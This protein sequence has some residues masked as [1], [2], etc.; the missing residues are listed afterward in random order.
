ML[1]LTV[2]RL[3][4]P[5]REVY[6]DCRPASCA[7]RRRGRPHSQYVSLDRLGRSIMRPL[8]G[9]PAPVSQPHGRS[10]CT[11]A[12]PTAIA[13][14]YRVLYA[15]SQRLGAFVETL[16]HFRP[17]P[18]VVAGR[19]EI[20]GEDDGAL[21]P[22]QVPTSW[23]EERLVAEGT[24]EGVF[25]DVGQGRSLS[26]L[27]TALASRIVHYD[28]ADLDGATIRISAPRRFTQEISRHVFECTDPGNQQIS[29]DKNSRFPPAAAASTK[30]PF[31]GH[32]LHHGWLAHPGRRASHA[33]RVPRCRVSPRA[34]FPPHLAVTQLPPA[35]TSDH[36][37]VQRTST[38]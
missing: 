4:H 23:A 20:E 11:I 6:V 17:D 34:S 18:G 14:R 2:E 37:L 1:C 9:R 3:D 5:G 7:C 26:H 33:V 21:L 35:R 22:G 19:A 36:L 10:G 32:G 31:G 13:R 15:C 16:A 30:R 27:R 28:M 24:I 29:P 38:S 12:R 25:A 8:A